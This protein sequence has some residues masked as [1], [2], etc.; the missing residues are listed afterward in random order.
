MIMQWFTIAHLQDQPITAVHLETMGKDFRR[1]AMIESRFF[2]NGFISSLQLFRFALMLSVIKLTKRNISNQLFNCYSLSLINCF[3]LKN[4]MFLHWS[5][6]VG[7]F[8]L[9]H[10]K[11][12]VFLA[13]YAGLTAS[14]GSCSSSAETMKVNSGCGSS[15]ISRSASNSSSWMIL[16]PASQIHLSFL[17]K[18]LTRFPIETIQFRRRVFKVKNANETNKPWVE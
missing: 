6:L 8:Y 14:G 18:Y 9:V 16:F 3:N 1:F 12:C 13:T 4:Y 17:F 10:S 11:K 5:K 15:L 2:Q 7:S